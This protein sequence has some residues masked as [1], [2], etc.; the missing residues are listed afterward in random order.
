MN[1]LEEAR[2][3]INTVDKEMAKLFERRMRASEKVAAYKKKW[4]CRFSMPCE[5][6]K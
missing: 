1:L 5:R 6:Q 4:D 3:E 2:L